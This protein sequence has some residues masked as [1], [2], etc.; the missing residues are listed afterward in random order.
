MAHTLVKNAS[1]GLQWE[2]TQSN[3]IRERVC[4]SYTDLYQSTDRKDAS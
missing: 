4:V 1:C 2:H 3:Y